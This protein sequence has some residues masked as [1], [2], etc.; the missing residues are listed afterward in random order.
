MTDTQQTVRIIEQLA[1]GMEALDEILGVE[2]DRRL[3]HPEELTLAVAQCLEPISQSRMA[4]T[5]MDFVQ[6]A[7]R[8][9]PCT[10]C[11]QGRSNNVMGK[12]HPV[13][14]MEDSSFN[15]LPL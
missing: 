2:V 1:G 12:I 6:D 10:R 9:P 4:A 11:T 14:I 13:P 8:R 3:R 7:T 5:A 15:G